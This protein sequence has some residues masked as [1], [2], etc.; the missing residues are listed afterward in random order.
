MLVEAIEQ[1]RR[2]Y[3]EKGK[4]EGLQEGKH[5][6]KREYARVMLA[7]GLSI[8]LISEITGISETEIRELQDEEDDTGTDDHVNN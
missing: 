6:A 8:A 1:D 4:Q 3:Y 2:T 7:K 5:E